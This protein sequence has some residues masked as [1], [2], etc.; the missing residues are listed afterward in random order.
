MQIKIIIIASL[1]CVRQSVWVRWVLTSVVFA[2]SSLSVHSGYHL[3]STKNGRVP[4]EQSPHTEPGTVVPETRFLLSQ[5]EQTSHMQLQVSEK[6][7]QQVVVIS[8]VLQGMRA[9]VV[10]QTLYPLH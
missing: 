5:M 1:T 6:G 3:G 10:T 8:F 7:T 2:Q 4:P 9:R